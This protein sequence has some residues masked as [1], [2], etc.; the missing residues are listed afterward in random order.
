VEDGTMDVT[1]DELLGYTDE[2]RAKWGNWF[3]VHGND[4]L[5]FAMPGDVHPDIGALILHCFWAELFYALW[6]QG[7]MLNEDRIKKENESLVKDQAAS[8]FAFGSSSRIAMRGFTAGATQEDWDRVHEVE[9]RG[10]RIKGPAR[11]LIAHILIHE[12]RHFAQMAIVV[13]QN[14]LAPPGDHDI[15]FSESFGSLLERN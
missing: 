6:M 13:H 1:I 14:G 15:L 4:P 2:E 9:G 3:S 7:E 5:K 8:I 12:I 11:K 10:V